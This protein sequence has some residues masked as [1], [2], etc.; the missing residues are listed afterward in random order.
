MKIVVA[1][2]GYVGSVTAGCF[3]NLGHKVV[4]VDVSRSKVEALV[5]GIPPVREP[6]LD[7]F[8]SSA[9]ER[10]SLTATPNLTDALPGSSIV[11]VCVGTP[12]G[13]DGR[14]SLEAVKAVVWEIGVA[15]KDE[16]LRGSFPEG[17]L[18]IVVR[19]TMLPGSSRS[20][21][22]PELLS[23]LGTSELPNWVGF[24]MQP[25][26]LREGTAVA[27]FLEP[28]K[29]V[30]G[31]TH[32][33]LTE[34]ILKLNDGLSGP[35]FMLE[36]DEAEMAKFID[37]SF[38]AVKVAFANEMGRLAT[39]AGIDA[40]RV[41]QPFLADYKLNIS[42]R[43]LRPGAPFGGS[44][45]PKDVRALRA[46]ADARGVEIP[47]LGAVVPSNDAHLD[48]ILESV[49]AVA[50]DRTVLLG[51]AFKSHTDDLRESPFLRIA[52]RLL[53][54]GS[55][56][57]CY[58]ASIVPD[59]LSGVNRQTFDD[60]LEE[61]GDGLEWSLGPPVI[62]E[63]DVVVLCTDHPKHLAAAMEAGL[64]GRTVID[65]TGRHLVSESNMPDVGITQES[66]E[67]V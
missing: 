37:N 32:S 12:S 11:L 26:F 61:S 30:F 19:S 65:L 27:D 4:G 64:T 44:C 39:Q 31:T 29:T 63:R 3:A 21:I 2:L 67:M 38:H 23:A 45:L 8:I 16:A 33:W 6:R 7:E 52:R 10:G 17:K 14:L 53:E 36:L 46:Y 41:F 20:E 66:T 24:G 22:I 60:W 34:R 55:S 54:H 50:R 43:Y 28:P 51:L 49:L 40:K 47:L 42:P 59:D 48:S 18:G 35:R 13:T 1:G 62:D 9:V 15:I 58:D 56:I 25:E 57:V 5:R